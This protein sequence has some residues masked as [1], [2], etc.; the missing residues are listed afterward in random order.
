MGAILLYRGH[1][2]VTADAGLIGAGHDIAAPGADR[3]LIGG[4]RNGVGKS[5]DGH[6]TVACP[7]DLLIAL[8]HFED[9]RAPLVVL[10]GDPNKGSVA[11][12]GV[13]GATGMGMGLFN[14]DSSLNV[15]DLL[16]CAQPSGGKEP[17]WFHDEPR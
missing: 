3:L 12:V 9:V 6:N 8:F 5:H 1:G 4:Q 7:I 15:S 14:V 10:H 2:G 13:K 16:N 11:H 17:L